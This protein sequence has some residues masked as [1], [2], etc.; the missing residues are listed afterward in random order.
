MAYNI[1]RASDARKFRRQEYIILYLYIS[2]YFIISGLHRSFS[3]DYVPRT[4][5][6]NKTHFSQ[7]FL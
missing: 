3:E 4:V 2:I 5:R 6:Q 1:P 7:I